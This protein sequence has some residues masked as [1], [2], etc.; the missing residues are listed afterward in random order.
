MHTRFVFFISAVL[1]LGAHTLVGE[2]LNGRVL[3]AATGNPA[4]GVA[5][6]LVGNRTGVVTGGDGRFSIEA[7]AGVDTLRCRGLEY[8]EALVPVR[9]PGAVEIRLEADL[10]VVETVE[11][12]AARPDRLPAHER[13]SSSV[14]IITR[15]TIPDR[16]AT[17]DQ[18]L[19]SEAGI[20]IRST[21][22]VGA[23]ADISI[24][25]SSTDQ[26]TVYLDGVPFSAGG[27]GFN[28]LG[29]VPLGQVDRIEVYRGSAP[30][31][32]G[33]GA[34][35]GVV[36]ITTVRTGAE[37]EISASASH[38]SFGTAHQSVLAAFGGKRNR[39]LLNAGR[40]ASDNDFRYFND[41]G[42]TIDTS[43]DGWDRRK[44]GDY[45]AMNFLGRWDGD[46]TEEHTLGATLSLTDTDRGVTGLGRRP[47]L[48]ARH[49]SRGVFAQ[50]RHRF[51]DF[52]DTRLWFMREK[53]H[54][55]DPDDE[56][57]RRGPQDTDDRIEVRGVLSRLH[58]VFGPVLFHGSVEIKREQY[59]ARDS[60][61]S[62]VTPPSHRT[63]AGAGIEAEIMLREG[64]LWISPRLHASRVRDRLRRMSSF[65]AHSAVDSAIAADRTPV[66]YGL[67]VR[68]RV[69]PG[70]VVRANGGS[71]SRLPE[72]GELFGDTGDVVGNTDLTEERG[73]TIDA[74]FHYTFGE[75]MLE[76][77]ASVFHRYADNLIQRRNYGDY[78]ISENIGKAEISGVETWIGFASTT[79]TLSGRLAFTYQDARNRS[80][81]TLFR[82]QRYYGKFLPY[83]PQ[84]KG[85]MSLN[86]RPLNR[87]HLKWDTDWESECFRGPSNLPD[88]KL[89]ARTIHT[90]SVRFTWRECFGVELEADNLTDDQ[91]PDRWGYPKPGRGY[92]LTLSWNWRDGS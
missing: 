60:F 59:E 87:V 68:Y 10:P 43:D 63:S 36:D 48:S 15:E 77:D 32:F 38:G 23:R 56:A 58:R 78:I 83:H 57:G 84:L 66:S 62:A 24:R 34:I 81:E 5:L 35:G 82:K 69:S 7:A 52:A 71:A 55:L 92:Y 47:V 80:D 11:V 70:F 28:G 12:Q 2:T 50:A 31:S 51:R 44:N 33:A 41:R 17:V 3:E 40:N 14:N 39:F 54:F 46:L 88:E 37:R 65:L 13:T 1:L 30:G 90:L 4:P 67:G 27:S 45:E 49:E 76:A 26:V 21:G 19:D 61:D 64:D 86:Y 6:Y 72:F 25:G 85:G 89:P 73:N 29:A 91:S 20:D 74:G 75:N 53:V 16:A 42:T 8:R 79:R 9:I 22:G 18:V